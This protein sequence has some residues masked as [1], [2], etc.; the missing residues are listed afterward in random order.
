MTASAASATLARYRW[1]FLVAAVY[2]LALGIAFFVAGQQ[3]FDWLD[4]GTVTHISYIHLPAIFV[5]VQGFSYLLVW[6]DPLAN[7]GIVKVGIVYKA[8]YS[9]LAAY[10][11]LTD[12]IPAMFF[13][14]FGLFDFLFLI[15][16]VLFLR[17]ANRPASRG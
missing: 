7:L 12:Q 4:M 8:G 9:L 13:A 11:L 6:Q 16:F 15:G 10:Y 1:F 5:A 3:I 2:D 14:W 17:W